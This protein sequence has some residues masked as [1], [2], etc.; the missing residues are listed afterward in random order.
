MSE[1]TNGDHTEG[2]I[3]HIRNNEI[4]DSSFVGTEL[5]EQAIRNFMDKVFAAPKI[6]KQQSD[7]NTR[8]LEELITTYHTPPYTTL[9]DFLAD[10]L[11]HH[12]FEIDPS[13][14][15]VRKKNAKDDDKF[16]YYSIQGIQ[17]SLNC[18]MVDLW[19]CLSHPDHFLY[20][21]VVTE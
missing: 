8:E 11:P 21:I 2:I 6:T 14:G 12:Y 19:R 15:I 9:G 1:T 5:Q 18:A 16:L 7:K 20:V 3:D 17:P 4:A 10:N 13:G